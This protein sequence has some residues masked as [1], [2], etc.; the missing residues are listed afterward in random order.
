MLSILA[1]FTL[2]NEVSNIEVPNIAVA[3]LAYKD[4]VNASHA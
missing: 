1:I 2:T 3:D 4:E